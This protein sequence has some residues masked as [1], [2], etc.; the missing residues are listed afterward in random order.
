MEMEIHAECTV[1]AFLPLLMAMAIFRM[2]TQRRPSHCSSSCWQARTPSRPGNDATALSRTRLIFHDLLVGVHVCVCVWIAG[3]DSVRTIT[4]DS[5]EFL[6]RVCYSQCTVGT[7]P[8]PWV[9]IAATHSGQGTPIEP[10]VPRA[11]PP[12][13]P[14]PASTK[15]IP[16]SKCLATVRFGLV[17]D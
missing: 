4:A 9:R 15:W 12:R 10:T 13:A 5:F 3:V 2:A 11:R 17:S 8:W 1:Y 6:P 7:S 14:L 16:A